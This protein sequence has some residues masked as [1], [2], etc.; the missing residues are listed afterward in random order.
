MGRLVPAG[1]EIAREVEDFVVVGRGRVRLRG[2]GGV[3][4]VTGQGGGGVRGAVW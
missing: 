1:S 3:D 2:G 4:L